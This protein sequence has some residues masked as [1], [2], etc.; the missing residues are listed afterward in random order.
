MTDISYPTH[1][2][3]EAVP[4]GPN[5]YQTQQFNNP[6]PQPYPQNGYPQNGYPQNGYPQNGFPMPQLPQSFQPMQ[7]Q[8]VTRPLEPVIMQQ[9]KPEQPT[10]L[11]QDVT[12]PSAR[13]NPV[14]NVG[15]MPTANPMPIANSM[16]TANPMHAQNP[17]VSAAYPPMPPMSGGG[18]GLQTSVDPEAQSLLSSV[19]KRMASKPK[20]E[21]PKNLPKAMME[22][23][24]QDIAADPTKPRSSRS[25]FLTGLLSGVVITYALI[26]CF[27]LLSRN[28]QQNTAA[29][30]QPSSQVEKLN[31]DLLAVQDID[32]LSDDFAETPFADVKPTKVASK[33]KTT[34]KKSQ[35]SEPQRNAGRFFIDE[36]LAA[37]E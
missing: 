5:P 18:G 4:A 22:K 29:Q 25:V 19:R 31:D 23:A 28:P 32:A 27:S 1:P 2:G 10:S 12:W 9:A 20:M 16:P 30:S 3:L 8:D 14:M 7:R 37:T 11:L 34:S 6:V 36:Q 26:T 13:V 35:L 33:P 21:A 24:N 15:A 17:S